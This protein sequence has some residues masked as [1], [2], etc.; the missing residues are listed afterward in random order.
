MK[1]FNKISQIIASGFHTFSIEFFPPKSTLAENNLMRAAYELK[2]INPDF[3]SITYG[4]GGS[5]RQNTFKYAGILKDKCNYNVMP[6]LTCVGHSKK[7][8]KEI[9]KN[10]NKSGF[11]TLMALRGDLPKEY[12]DN[13]EEISCFKY[14]NQLVKLIDSTNLGFEIGVAG[15]PEKHP[16]AVS[17]SEDIF[18][19]KKKVDA[20]ASFITTQLFYNNLHYYEFIEQCRSMDI[21]CP[22]IP[23]LM[24]PSNLEKVEKFCNFCQSEFPEK[25]KRN[26][27]NTSNNEESKKSMAINWTFNQIKE[28]VEY[29]VPGIHLYIMNQSDY[30]LSLYE[31]LMR[32]K[33]LNR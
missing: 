33:I 5:S 23:G 6:H 29:G 20:G 8:L 24:I 7:E 21:K 32:S 11:K 26:L 31:N 15:Y 13:K 19:L 25:L 1:T 22:V 3:V 10:Y 18:N 14:A 9:I 16:E 17:L 2:K 12:N 28:L 30:A 27:E 4:A